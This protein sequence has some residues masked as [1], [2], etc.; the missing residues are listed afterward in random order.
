MQVASTISPRFIEGFVEQCM[1]M[2]LTA[3][4]TEDLFRKHAHN[5]LI[6]RPD[7][8]EGFRGVVGEYEGP[9][10]KSAMARW[11]NPDMIALA[12]ELRINY[13]DDPLSAQ[14]RDALDLPEPSWDTV[15]DNIKSAA[16]GLSNIIDQFDYLP[17]NQKILLA[18]M[19]GGGLGGLSRG[20]RP[21]EDDEALGRGSFNRV[22]RGALRG[23]GTGAGVA[24]GA[25]AGSDVAGRFDPGMRLP[26]LL[27]GGTLGGMAGKNLASQIIA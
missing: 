26:G 27:M 25:A 13:G 1:Q 19:A 11:M 18:V 10:T 14:M 22:T 2:G 15:P 23:A 8:Y 4:Q 9:L 21:T 24:A 12:E 6:A 5:T 7:I 3:D 17:L 20:L 16:A